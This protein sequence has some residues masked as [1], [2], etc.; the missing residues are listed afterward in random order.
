MSITAVGVNHRYGLTKIMLAHHPPP[1]VGSGL[2]SE[3]GRPP[4][5]LTLAR[6]GK[7]V[8]GG[9]CGRAVNFHPMT[10]GIPPPPTMGG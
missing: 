2:E 9:V 5:F 3:I 8:H 10:T 4:A 1:G 7:L 6:Q